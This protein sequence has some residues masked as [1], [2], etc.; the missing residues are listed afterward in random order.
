MSIAGE[1]CDPGTLWHKE[2]GALFSQRG[3]A[4]KHCA[5]PAI[6]LN[7]AAAALESD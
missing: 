3:A 4:V 1:G 6:W 2:N 5:S 7:Q